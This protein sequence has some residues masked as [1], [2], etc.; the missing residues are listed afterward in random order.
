M[1]RRGSSSNRRVVCC[2]HDTSANPRGNKHCAMDEMIVDVTVSK[3]W[4]P[5]MIILIHNWRYWNWAVASYINMYNKFPITSLVYVPPLIIHYPVYWWIHVL[6]LRPPCHCQ[7]LL[8]PPGDWICPTWQKY[9]INCKNYSWWTVKYEH[10]F[11]W[12]LTH[13]YYR[14]LW[15]NN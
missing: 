13:N 4:S 11:L 12:N 15:F 1:R 7:F 8:V 9:Y 10:I 3:S 6:E 14:Y 2:E 5:I